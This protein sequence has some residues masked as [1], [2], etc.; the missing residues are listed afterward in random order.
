MLLFSIKEFLFS[1]AF[2]YRHKLR[3]PDYQEKVSGNGWWQKEKGSFFRSL[4]QLLCLARTHES[5]ETNKTLQDTIKT[6]YIET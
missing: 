4:F 3:Y 6:P 2:L 1:F 5:Q